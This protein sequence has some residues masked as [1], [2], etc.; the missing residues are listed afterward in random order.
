MFKNLF[1]HSLIF[2]LL[3]FC[4]ST[5]KPIQRD[6]VPIQLDISSEHKN[7]FLDLT[8]ENYSESELVSLFKSRDE[9]S[10][11]VCEMIYGKKKLR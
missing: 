8:K 7:Y 3:L 4:Q 9:L 6:K 1:F 10:N 2:L 5:D 11:T